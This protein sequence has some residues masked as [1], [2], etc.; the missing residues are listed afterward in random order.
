[1]SRNHQRRRLTNSAR[2]TELPERLREVL[3]LRHYEEMSFEEISRLLQIPASTLK[4]R[5]ARALSHLRESLRHIDVLHE[6]N[7]P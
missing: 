2:V 7:G 5:F 1:M 4:S 3:V 6:E